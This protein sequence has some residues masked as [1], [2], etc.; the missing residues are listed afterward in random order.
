MQTNPIEGRTGDVQDQAEGAVLSRALELHPRHLSE[1]DLSLDLV[2]D[3]LAGRCELYEHA[4]RCLA[5][6]G[7]LRVEGGEVAPTA[8]ALRASEVTP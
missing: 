6:A 7:L 3:T 5:D 8:A 4:I 2:G 1:R